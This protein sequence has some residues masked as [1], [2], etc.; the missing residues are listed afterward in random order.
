[1]MDNYISADPILRLWQR[2]GTLEMEK[3]GVTDATGTWVTNDKGGRAALRKHGRDASWRARWM[4]IC[5]HLKHQFTHAA[6]CDASPKI[7]KATG[8]R[9]LAIGYYMGVQ[10]DVDGLPDK[11]EA[12]R[13][14]AGMWG[15]AVPSNWEIMDAELYAILR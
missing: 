3:G 12:G 5:L 11:D 15:M 10:P 2:S 4:T 1:M 14:G 9:R 6:A 7:D 13:V 8:E